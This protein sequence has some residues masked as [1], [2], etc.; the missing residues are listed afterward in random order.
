MSINRQLVDTATGE[1]YDMG[2]YYLR[3]RASDD[4]YKQFIVQDNR[5]FSFA[6]MEN[7][8]EVIS[9]ISTVH[10][11]YLLILQCYMEMDTGKLKLTTKQIPSVIGSSTSTFK[12]FWCEMKKFGI[13]IAYKG[14]YYVNPRFHFRGKAEG[15]R[16]IKLFLT[17]LKRLRDDITPSELGFLY[18]LLPY[19]HY[20]TNMICADPFTEPENIQFLNKSQIAL[21]V[22]II[23]MV[24]RTN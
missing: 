7:I 2:E 11:G 19:V 4:A 18:K 20:D 5:H 15:K 23:L 22:V 13:I 1:V 8:R 17:N 9:C 3:S 10:C 14:E 24:A 21:L 12:R 6:D 16:V